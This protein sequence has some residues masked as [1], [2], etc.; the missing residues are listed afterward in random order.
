MN[1]RLTVDG[2]FTK[3]K[4]DVSCF[5]FFFLSLFFVEKWGFVNDVRAFHC[6]KEMKYIFCL[7]T[8]E[9]VNIF[10]KHKQLQN[11][12]RPWILS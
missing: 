1:H 2:L 6:N 4:Q 8:D 9:K 11:T 10:V 7:V 3:T 5:F 12:S